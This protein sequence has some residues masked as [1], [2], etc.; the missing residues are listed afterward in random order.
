MPVYLPT[1][2]LGNSNNL[3]TLGGSGEVMAWFYPHKDAFQHITACLPC[4]YFGHGQQGQLH[5][6][7]ESSFSRE[8]SYVGDSN[9]LRTTL[10]SGALEL[11]FDD[12]MLEDFPVLA[13]RIR[14]SNAGKARWNGG[15]YHLN[16][17]KMGGHHEGNGVRF[18]FE[19]AMIVQNHRE[20]ALAVGGDAVQGHHLGKAG[21]NWNNNARYALER[22]VLA[23]NELEIGDVNFAA[24]FYADLAAGE[25]QERTLY[26]ALG[27]SENSA[28]NSFAIARTRGFEHHFNE[29]VRLDTAFLKRGLNA[30]E[31]AEAGLASTSNSTSGQLK[32]GTSSTRVAQEA[33]SA[34]MEE[35]AISGRLEEGVGRASIHL[36][37]ELFAAY[38]RSL[39]ALPLLNGE[40]GAAVAAPEFDPEFISCGGY[41][42]HWPRDGGEYISGLLDAG[43]SEFA[44]GFFEWCARHQDRRGLWHQR[45][46]L[47]GQLAPNWCLPPDTLQIDEVGAVG[48][49]FGKTLSALPD[50]EV[51]DESKQMLQR[52]SD[53]LLTRLDSRTGV[54]QNA[55][56]TWETFIGSFTYSNAAIY[57]HLVTS[58][59]VCQ[60]LEY[61]AGAARLKAG[62]LG[63]FVRQSNGLRFLVRGFKSDGAPD[64]TIDSANLGAIEPFGLLDLS[65][66][67]ELDLAI[68][69]LQIITEKLE[70]PWQGGRAIR[71]FEGDEYVGGVPACVNTLW[72]ARCCLHV[73]QELQKRG[74]N[75][76]ASELIERAEGF[77]KVVLTRATPTGLLPELMQG[78]EG[79]TFWAAPHGWAMASFVSGVLKLARMKA[80]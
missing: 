9:I 24:G 42:Y 49:A 46:H 40:E 56:D 48:W 39:L 27:Q 66:D 64:E 31:K 13:R 60:N 4:V 28:V 14:V 74:R 77:L 76:Q 37:D 67:D 54:H 10:K 33:T 34:L 75:P 7:F 20:Y 51:T 11:Q 2:V 55:F 21:A 16:H 78:P 62:V 68:G 32:D 36:D 41:G 70:V 79:Q 25:T 50:F 35:G 5:F 63:H 1:S 17:F 8:Q 52:S 58:A 30:L 61:G 38:K 80:H 3:V 69:T 15:I 12:V 57:A 6:T 18:D 53:Y 65:V 59:L 44:R 47:N 22:G 45:Y 71:R 23:G 29:R 43:Y 72:M 26:F 19:A 73:A